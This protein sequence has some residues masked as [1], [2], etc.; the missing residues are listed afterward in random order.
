MLR[1]VI[2][3]D[4]LSAIISLELLIKK[5]VPETIVTAKTIHPLEGV[6]LIN[7]HKPDIVFLDIQMPRLNGFDMLEKLEFRDFYL[8]FTTAYHEYALKALKISA[9]DYLLKPVHYEELKSTIIRIQQKI[10]EKQK[11]PDVS[12][13]LNELHNRYQPKIPLQTKDSI[14]YLPPREVV[15]LEAEGRNTII[16]LLDKSTLTSTCPLGY[17][18]DLLCRNGLSFMRIHNSF[19]INLRYVTRYIRENGGTVIMNHQKTIPVS[20]KIKEEFLKYIM[21][22]AE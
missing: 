17:Y 3:D 1:A 5:F 11:I 15:Y 9:T 21:L 8:V 7:K 16:K 20:K 4:E 18:E 14:E 6:D 19:V 13:L 22:N 10:N 2:I 12:V